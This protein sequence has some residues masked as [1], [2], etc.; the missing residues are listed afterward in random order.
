MTASEFADTGDLNAI[1][2][3][4]GTLGLANSTRHAGSTDSAWRETPF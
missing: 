4:G 3:T 2:T 1:S